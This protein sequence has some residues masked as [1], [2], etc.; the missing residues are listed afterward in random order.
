MLAKPVTTHALVRGL[1]TKGGNRF[2]ITYD[3][4][5]LCTKAGVD[6]NEAPKDCKK[7]PAEKD[8]DGSWTVRTTTTSV[9][10]ALS[11]TVTGTLYPAGVSFDV[12]TKNLAKQKASN[13]VV[14]DWSTVTVPALLT[15]DKNEVTTVTG[16]RPSN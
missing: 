4:V 8:A 11:S 15:V 5:V 6:A 3:P 2:T 14:F 13:G 16:S 1:G 12:T 7:K 10:V 9:I